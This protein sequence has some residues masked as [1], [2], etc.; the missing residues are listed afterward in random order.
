MGSR[1]ARHAGS[2]PDRIKLRAGG[3]EGFLPGWRRMARLGDWD[4]GSV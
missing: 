4:W 1:E 3:K 2:E